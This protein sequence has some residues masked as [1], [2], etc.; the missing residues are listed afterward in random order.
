MIKK[1]IKR[2]F[3]H[4]LVARCAAAALGMVGAKRHGYRLLNM[5]NSLPELLI[6]PLSRRLF[7]APEIRMKSIGG[8]DQ[9]ARIAGVRGWKVFERPLPELYAGFVNSGCVVFD[10]G[11]NT[12]FYTLLA[13]VVDQ[14]V[15]IHSFE[16]V[17]AIKRILEENVRLNGMGSDRVRINAQALGSECGKSEFYLPQNDHGLVETSASLNKDFRG[18]HSSTIEVDVTTIDSYMEQNHLQKIDLIK[19][20][21]ESMEHIV[22][23][24]ALS[25]LTRHRPVIFIEVLDTADCVAL[26]SIANESK[27]ISIHLGKGELQL[28]ESIQSTPLNPNQILWPADKLD[29]LES[30]AKSM[31][32]EVSNSVPDKE[33]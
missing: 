7:S 32:L 8:R 27:Y 26:N 2:L 9:V 21:V 28:Q 20:D 13:G 4:R 12:G 6:I 5:V 25:T 11:A 22:L 23:G 3:K 29:Q 18:A 16:P 31:K 10:I 30:Y 1:I 17:P 19:V 24:G 15:K 14:S 33:V